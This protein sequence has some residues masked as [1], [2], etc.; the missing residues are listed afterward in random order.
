VTKK[1]IEAILAENKKLAAEN[2]KLRTEVIAL[3]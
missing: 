2:E 3:Q 1:E